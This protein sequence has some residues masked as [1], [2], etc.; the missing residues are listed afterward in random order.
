MDLAAQLLRH[1]VP[2]AGR[3]QEGASSGRGCSSLV[4]GACCTTRRDV[5]MAVFSMCR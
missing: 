2:V 1:A 5:I 3:Q 4:Y